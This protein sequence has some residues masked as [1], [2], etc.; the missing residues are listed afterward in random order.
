MRPSNCWHFN[1][2][3]CG[4][5]LILRFNFLWIWL[6]VV[7]IDWHKQTTDQLFLDW[8][9]LLKLSSRP[10][11]RKHKVIHAPASQVINFEVSSTIKLSHHQYL[12]TFQ[13]IYYV[14]TSCPSIYQASKQIMKKL[15]YNFGIS[16]CFANF[17]LPT[18]LNQFNLRKRKSK[19]N[20]VVIITRN[21]SLK[22]DLF[23]RIL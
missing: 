14:F 2:G 1:E 4:C 23:A 3:H 21:V 13:T 15:I 8:L 6:S 11:K 7:E 12:P 9:P 5:R 19:K 10:E 22:F 20:F 18:W 16:R 17:I